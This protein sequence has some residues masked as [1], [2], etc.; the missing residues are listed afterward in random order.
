MN[1]ESS[2]L[3]IAETKRKPYRKPRLEQ[4][5]LVLEEAVLGKSCKLNEVDL[6]PTGF[7][8]VPSPCSADNLGS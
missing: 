8:V 4:V 3:R 1:P 2:E 7:C 6:G 5:R